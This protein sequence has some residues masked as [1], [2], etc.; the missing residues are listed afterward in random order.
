[1][2][3][4]E[5]NRNFARWNNSTASAGTAHALPITVLGLGLSG[6]FTFSFVVCILGYLVWP[7]G[8][9]QHASLSIFLPGFTLLSWQSFFLGLV[10]S[11]IWG[12]YIAV[13]FG[14]I[15]N[16]FARRLG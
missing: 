11:F 15:Y 8:P 16:F 12:W 3:T 5:S 6:F 13:V 4:T 7:N 14:S 1:M 2:A 9:A 10:E